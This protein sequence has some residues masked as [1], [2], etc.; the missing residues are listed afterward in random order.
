MHQVPDMKVSFIQKFGEGSK[1]V[2]VFYNLTCISGD[3]KPEGV[4]HL[5][6]LLGA[7][8]QQTTG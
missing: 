3:M 2:L 7:R 6:C 4:R 1:V 8:Y 5:R